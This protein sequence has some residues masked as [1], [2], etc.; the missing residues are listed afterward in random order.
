MDILKNEKGSIWYGMHFYPGV[1]EYQPPG[2][3]AY[4]VFLNEETI[5]SMDPTFAGRPIFVEHV[6]GVTQKLDQ[7]RKEADGWVIESFYNSADGK[8]WVKF[9]AVSENAQTAIRNGFR[10]S[11]AY[12]PTSKTQGGLWNGVEYAFEITAGEYEHLAIVRNPRYEESRILSPEEFKS[13][14]EKHLQE[15]KRLANS[16]DPKQGEDKMKLNFFKKAKVENAIDLELSVM[17]PKSGKEMTV[18]EII[19]SA[20]DYQSMKKDNMADMGHMV[21]LHD[22]SM[23][24]VGELVEKHKAMHDELS[25]M[26]KQGSEEE[27]ATKKESVQVDDPKMNEESEEDKEKKKNEE[28]EKKKQ[29]EKKSNALK[30]A[31]EIKNAKDEFIRKKQSE[32]LGGSTGPELLMSNE[33]VALGKKLFGSDQVK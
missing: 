16:K 14:N 30:A 18:S 22:G 12:Q 32:E 24:N 20:D 7:L 2:Q 4:R 8:H 15:L 1:A 19:N 29:E 13:Y 28:E 11:N 21:K 31:N 5:R 17:L 27:L 23:C 26:K 6:D 25:G 33:K 9:I 10:L 3:A